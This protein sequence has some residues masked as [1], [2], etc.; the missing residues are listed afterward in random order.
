[1]III[2]AFK[3]S[4]L[5]IK[6]SN[7][8]FVYMINKQYSN[9]NWSWF[10]YIDLIFYDKNNRNQCFDHKIETKDNYLNF[11]YKRKF[12]VLFLPSS[13]NLNTKMN[14]RKVLQEGYTKSIILDIRS[15]NVK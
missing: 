2:T 4:V 1:M 7:Y 5:L 8:I 12:Y 11:I 6:N 9:Y 10:N 14:S 15:D 3:N 13:S